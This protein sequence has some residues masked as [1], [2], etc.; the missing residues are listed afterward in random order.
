MPEVDHL[1]HRSLAEG[2]LGR[3]LV[4]HQRGGLAVEVGPA[5]ERVAQVLVARH[6]GEDPQLDLAVVGRDQ[7]SG[8]APPA[9]NA[10]R[11]R[12]P[13]GVRIGMFWRFGS[14]DDRRPVAAT[15]WWNVVWSRSSAAISVGSASTY[16]ER[17]FV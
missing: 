3:V 12:R 16:V 17:S 14:D 2:H 1:G 6:V 8:P 4:Q 10:R 15:A 5:R 11:I 7:A 13:S 9:T